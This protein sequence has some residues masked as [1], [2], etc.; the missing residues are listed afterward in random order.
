MIYNDKEIEEVLSL[1]N[2]WCLRDVLK[3]L[4]RA[5]NILLHDKNYD[6]HGWEG[7]SHC[8]DRGNEIIK[9]LERDRT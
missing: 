6:G 4:V 2:P 8:V 7:I 9:I 3:E 5:S 1:D